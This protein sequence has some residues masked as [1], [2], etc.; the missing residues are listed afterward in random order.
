MD[1]RDFDR[2]QFWEYL[3]LMEVKRQMIQSHSRVSLHDAPD[4]SRIMTFF[5]CAGWRRLVKRSEIWQS[6]E[7]GQSFRLVHT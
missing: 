7:F 6:L 4:N 2:L 1:A 3:N 5:A